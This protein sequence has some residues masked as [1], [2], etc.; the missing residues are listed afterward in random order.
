[1]LN[2]AHSP[3]PVKRFLAFSTVPA[4]LRDERRFVLWREEEVE[5]RPTKVPYQANGH[6][7]QPNNK[8]TWTTLSNVLAELTNGGDYAGPGFMLGGGFCGI[9][10]DVCL[11]PET[12]A[13]APW[14]AEVLAAIPTYAE[15]SPSGR[16]IKL[17]GWCSPV[18]KIQR[19]KLSPPKF[20][21]DDE[22][23]PEIALFVEKR[24]FTLTG[25]RYGDET[26]V[27][28]VDLSWLIGQLD[29]TPLARL[30][31]T[32][33]HPGKDQSRSGADWAL[34]CLLAKLDT[35]RAETR[36]LLRT[37]QWG[38][39]D[40]SERDLDRL[41]DRPETRG[42]VIKK[43]V[44][45]LTNLNG[46][47]AMLQVPHNPT[48][49]ILR[50]KSRPIGS[51][52]FSLRLAGEVVHVGFDD[53][54]RPKYAT[55]EKAWLGS[56]EKHVYYSIAFT[57]AAVPEH[58]MNL[59]TGYGCPAVPGDCTLIKRHL[60]EVWAAGDATVAKALFDLLAWQLQHVGEPS[61]IVVV[62]VAVQQAGRGTFIE[63]VLLPIWGAH[64]FMT[65]DLEHITGNFND[66]LRGMG[67]V[68]LDEALFGG[69]RK[70][71]SKI[72]GIVATRRLAFNQKFVPL[73]TLPCAVNLWILS[74]AE[75]PAYVEEG[76]ARYWT[77]RVS[78]ARA[79]DHAYFGALLAE[80]R[81]GGREAFLA[82][83]LT[84]DV[85]DFI[86]QR[87][88]PRRNELHTDIVRRGLNPG[89]PRFF[90]EELKDTGI[91][92]GLYTRD[93]YDGLEMIAG[94]SRQVAPGKTIP[95]SDVLTSYRYWVGKLRDPHARTVSLDDFWKAL[96]EEGFEKQRG[97]GGERLR[98]IPA[99]L[100]PD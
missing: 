19:H 4:R 37:W 1:M 27:C 20:L 7:A 11:N 51:H 30:L 42:T 86:P 63:E 64:G 77:L 3:V 50:D 88:V 39:P 87:D 18:P 98:L 5:G 45:T 14:A 80:V 32:G 93:E 96:S 47:F 12:G 97:V 9:D 25:N 2:L 28:N 52:D 48:V 49:V 94:H 82:E 17:F 62:L 6:H 76:D 26:E 66:A 35:P 89:D 90:L 29:E 72:K 67:F 34:A 36:E 65:L 13:L 83:L 53:E 100:F 81:S 22:R 16:G 10:L 23:S 46:R 54:G 59:W 21:L 73:V 38:Q 57:G 55:A 15:I 44:V 61:R 58:T 33:E 8:R 79:C 69:D 60:T 84:R 85:S 43:R 24:Y 31:R 78:G 40:K 91:W 56:C 99:N 68:V 41:L 95:S 74:N 71:A 92:P 75:H 70:G